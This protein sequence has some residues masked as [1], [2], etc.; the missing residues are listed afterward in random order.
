[1]IEE[2]R[3]IAEKYQQSGWWRDPIAA[4]LYRNVVRSGEVCAPYPTNIHT[5]IHIYAPF[6]F[7]IYTTYI[8]SVMMDVQSLKYT[9]IHA[10]KHL[11][12]VP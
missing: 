12:P 10:Y 2:M 9:C 1:M 4:R 11:I 8:H 6:I 3:S 7:I 5:Y